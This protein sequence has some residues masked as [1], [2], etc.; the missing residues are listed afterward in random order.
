MNRTIKPLVKRIAS[1]MSRVGFKIDKYVAVLVLGIS[2]LLIL[3]LLAFANRPIFLIPAILMG[4]ISITWISTRSNISDYTDYELSFSGNIK[5]VKLLN[6][7]FFLIVSIYT[8]YIY[9]LAELGQRST[10][11]FVI[12]SILSGIVAIEIIFTPLKRHSTVGI[13]IKTI[14][15]SLLI[16]LPQILNYA[17]PVGIDP[18]YHQRMTLELLS[19]NSIPQGYGYS[20]LPLFHVLTSISMLIPNLGY[21]LST[22]FSISMASTI[23]NILWIYILSSTI[24]R[25]NQ[26]GLFGSLLLALANEQIYFSMQPIPNTLAVMFLLPFLYC[27]IKLKF[28]PYSMTLLLSIFAVSVILTHSLSSV[29]ICIILASMYIVT[30]TYNCIFNA[31]SD[32]IS[33][34]VLLFWIIFMISWWSYVSGHFNWFIYMSENSFAINYLEGTNIQSVNYM[35]TVSFSEQLFNNLGNFFFFSLAV[36]GALYILKEKR[37]A[38]SLSIVTAGML[39][40]FVGYLSIL[41]PISLVE[42]R[43]FYVAQIFLCIPASISILLINKKKWDLRGYKEIKVITIVLII[44]SLSF[45]LSINAHSNI[46]HNHY[47]SETGIRYALTDSEMRALNHI[48]EVNLGSN[49]Y[50]DQYYGVGTNLGI[51]LQS[52]STSLIQK[53]FRDCDGIILIREEICKYPFQASDYPY[54]LSYDPIRILENEHRSVIYDSKSVL[55]FMR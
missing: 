44:V 42:S 50:S 43:W 19:I 27:V 34:Y 25:N 38:L 48:D 51:P 35:N 11:H 9:Q 31:K 1:I 22:V 36:I 23:C 41:T 26:M 49:I 2:I 13:L 3:Y 45:L 20:K 32:H 7:A 28:H 12:I 52:M 47:L 24:F 14:L 55:G 29:I 6:I 15:L 10:I 16:I 18:W 17:N 53:S 37:N 54:K 30:R 33:F 39:I 40:Q 5:S 4:V 8:I 46:E 21:K